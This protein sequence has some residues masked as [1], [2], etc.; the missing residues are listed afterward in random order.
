MKKFIFGA[1]LMTLGLAS[2][3]QTEKGTWLLGGSATINS[4]STGDAK[5]SVVGVNPNVGLF[6]ADNFGAG[7]NIGFASAKDD[8]DTKTNTTYVAPFIRYYFLDLGTSAKLFANASY[9]FGSVK[10]G[11]DDALNMSG[12]SLSAGP[13]FFLNKNIAFNVA[14]EYSSMKVKDATDATNTLGANVGLQIHFKK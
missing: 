12:W 8:A 9:A 10:A 5:T 4:S 6:L 11:N 2:Q 1:F 14:L 7:L 13:S 3:A